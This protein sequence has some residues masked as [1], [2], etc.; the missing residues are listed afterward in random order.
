MER[1]AVIGVHDAVH[2]RAVARNPTERA[3]LCAVGMHDVVVTAASSSVNVRTAAASLRGEIGAT[4]LA[5]RMTSNPAASA[6][7]SRSPGG[8]PRTASGPDRTSGPPS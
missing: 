5:T 2:V 4:R 1:E 3:R 6:A 7:A 8:A